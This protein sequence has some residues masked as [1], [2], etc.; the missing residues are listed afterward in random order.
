MHISSFAKR[1]LL[2]LSASLSVISSVPAVPRS[3]VSSTLCFR[4]A[5]VALPFLPAVF[6]GSPFSSVVLLLFSQHSS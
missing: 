5:A 3:A 4:S 6:W 2:S 1:A